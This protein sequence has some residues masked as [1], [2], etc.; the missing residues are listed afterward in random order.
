MQYSAILRNVIGVPGGGHSGEG[1]PDASGAPSLLIIHS[2]TL[3][4][5]A[6]PELS[7]LWSTNS[8]SPSSSSG[9]CL[10]FHSL[11]TSDHNCARGSLRVPLASSFSNALCSALVHVSTLFFH[12]S[13]RGLVCV[14]QCWA[15]TSL[16]STV[17]KRS[18]HSEK[19][20]Q[21]ELHHHLRI[22][23]KHFF[24]LPTFIHV[25]HVIFLF[26]SSTIVCNN[27]KKVLQRERGKVQQY[28]S[29]G[30]CERKGSVQYI[31]PKHKWPIQPRSRLTYSQNNDIQMIQ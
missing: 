29:E 7:S 9:S 16:E 18:G 21:H 2:W 10:A 24:I 31:H 6:D 23:H 8:S 15:V 4:D 5:S 13:I 28:V 3:T 20:L 17:L 30:W 22:N 11:S 26:K 1:D 14:F 12:F 25:E 27:V 19:L